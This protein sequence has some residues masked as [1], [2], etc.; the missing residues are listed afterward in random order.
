MIRNTIATLLIIALIFVSAKAGKSSVRSTDPV[1]M[2]GKHSYPTHYQY[3]PKVEQ[4]PS[5][6]L[7]KFMGNYSHGVATWLH[8]NTR[9]AGRINTQSIDWQGILYQAPTSVSLAQISF[10]FDL[11]ADFI[12]VPQLLAGQVYII[13]YALYVLRSGIA[14]PSI[15]SP[16]NGA[17]KTVPSSVVASASSPADFTNGNV[18]WTAPGPVF[19][20]IDG[21][22]ASSTCLLKVDPYNDHCCCKLK[23]TSLDDPAVGPI[24]LSPGDQI[25]LAIQ[26]QGV[27]NALAAGEGFTFAGTLNWQF[28]FP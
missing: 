22:V 7:G 18:D 5:R 8:Q 23:Y 6:S 20:L 4:I 10:N 17:A 2:K 27:N 26:Y 9:F 28:N 11:I 25:R 1:I 15:L 21:V 3:H 14:A 19:P 12:P 13:S 16:T 24:L